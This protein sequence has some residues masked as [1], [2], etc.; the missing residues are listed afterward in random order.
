MKKISKILSVVMLISMISV[1]VQAETD[2]DVMIEAYVSNVMSLSSGQKDSY[3]ELLDLL[4]NLNDS[5]GML[6]A[7]T[8]A[9]NGMSGGD[10]SKFQALKNILV[11]L[12]GINTEVLD[13]ELTLS[14]FKS[15]LINNDDAGLE[16]ALKARSEAFM[17]IL[18]GMNLELMNYGFER[19]KTM[20]SYQSAAAKLNSS[21][22]METTGTSSDFTIYEKGVETILAFSEYLPELADVSEGELT[23]A[24]QVLASYYNNSSEK[25]LLYTFFVDNGLVKV[26]TTGT[27]SG[28]GTGTGSGAGTEPEPEVE[29]ELEA[30]EELEEEIIE[31]LGEDNLVPEGTA[32]FGDIGR[33]TWAWTA[34]RELYIA[35]VI[36]GKSETE[37]DP[38]GDITRAEFSALLCRLLE[39]SI[40]TDTPTLEGIFNDV[41]RDKWY[42]SE[43]MA[44]F[45]AGFVKGVS[46]TEFD[47]SANIN[48]EQ[49]A[50]ILS[51]VLVARGIEAISDEEIDTAISKFSDGDQVSAWARAG[52]ALVADLEIIGGVNVGEDKYFNFKDNATRAEVSVMLYRLAQLIET[53]V[54]VEQ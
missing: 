12:E 41:N 13:S 6:N 9:M 3:L 54:N 32:L 48:R 1:P 7:Y 28:A 44:A 19:L 11:N 40:P 35:D 8:T 53:K 43:V 21:Y 34:I 4:S 30:E 27:G 49:I 15:Y 2:S 39:T 46:V 10:Q 22:I 25:G 38:S 52:S 37:F 50:T 5:T 47:P 33:F 31:D 42:Y 24:I 26:E 17:T 29:P 23:A 20:Y 36:K 14:L 16:S 51:R 45:R 18:G